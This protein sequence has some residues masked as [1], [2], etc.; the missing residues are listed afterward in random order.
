[1]E[2][3]WGE[4]EHVGNDLAYEQEMARRNWNRLKEKHENVFIDRLMTGER[5]RAA[6]SAC[7]SFEY[8]PPS[9]PSLPSTGWIQGRN[10][11]G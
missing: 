3:V 2:D 4:E 8:Y 1:M 10:F 7:Q 6:Q 5:R 11:P 9:T